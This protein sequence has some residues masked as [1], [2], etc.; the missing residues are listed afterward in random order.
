M[1][2]S[3]AGSCHMTASANASGTGCAASVA[4]EEF[5]HGRLDIK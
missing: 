5:G 4:V 2:R 3:G 1:R